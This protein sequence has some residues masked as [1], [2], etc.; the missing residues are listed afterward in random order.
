MG[1]QDREKA[2]FFGVKSK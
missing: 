2:T 1:H